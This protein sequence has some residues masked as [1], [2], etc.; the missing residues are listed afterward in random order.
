MKRIISLLLT[1]TAIIFCLF[2]MASCD[3]DPQPDETVYYTVSFNLDGGIVDGKDLTSA[4]RVKKETVIDLT[5]YVPEKD[6]YIFGGWKLGETVYQSSDSITVT[7]DIELVALWTPIPTYTVTFNASE[8]ALTNRSVTAKE[9]TVIRFADYIPVREDYDFIGWKAEDNTIYKV[10][11]SFTVTES[12]SFIAVWTPTATDDSKFIFSLADD[13]KSYILSSLADDFDVANVV[14]PGE[15]NGKPVTEIAK[16]VFF[17]NSTITS[18]DLSRCTALKTIGSFNFNNCENLTSVN[19]EGCVSLETISDSCFTSLPKLT[20]LN[21]KSLAKLE[22]IGSHCF[23]YGGMGVSEIPAEILDF[24]ECVSLKKIGDMS[25]WYLSGVKLLDFSNT[26][27]NSIGKQFIK[28]CTALEVI[29]LPAT[30]DPAN[31]GYEF[32][33]NT[34]M[35]KEI[36]VDSLSLYLCSENGV[37]YDIDKTVIYK[38]PAA[39]TATQYKAPST[40]KTVKS[41]AFHDAKN[42]TVIDFTECVLNTVDWQAFAGCS[43][44]TLKMSFSADGKNEDGSSVTLGSNWNKDVPSVEYIKVIDISF[45]GITDGSTVSTGSV[46]LTANATYGEDKIDLTVTLNGETVNSDNGT[47]ILN[48]VLG[49]NTVVLSADHNGKSITKTIKITRI[50]GQLEVSTDLASKVLSWYGSTVN[51]TIN[52]K[53]ASGV[54]LTSSAVTVQ[55]NWGYGNYNQTMGVTM[56]DNA[57]GTVSISVSYDNYYDQ[58]Y[59]YEDTEITLTVIVKDGDQSKTFVCTVDWREKAPSMSV[60]TTLPDKTVS[61]YGS[62]VDF[63]INAKSASGVALT[64]SAVTVQY[65]WGYGNYNQTMGVTMTDNADG[66]VSISVSYDNY[67]DQFYIYED[68]EI[69]L[70]VIVKD[71]D[72][73]KTFVCTVDW[74]E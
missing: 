67:Y 56:T 10:T 25:F 1:A 32:I 51:F 40:I 30:L 14:I 16:S 45:S 33:T 26:K 74:K 72:Q 63:T 19:L 49:E 61:G 68:T 69:T 44:A 7:A 70:T 2:A 57:D 4:L 59:I 71:G 15:Y 58:F 27:L 43:S 11:D 48:L 20:V 46:T 12:V 47:Y 52:A 35:L 64:S 73:S 17:Y 62:T 39:N 36:N 34:P 24:S 41:Q 21:L 66:T 9:G 8:A 53:S 65:N 42:L 28:Q 54:A 29:S 55:Y 13:E 18:V 60:T 37:L 23:T 38:Y 6:E 5:E 22:E 50:E 3:D 31:I